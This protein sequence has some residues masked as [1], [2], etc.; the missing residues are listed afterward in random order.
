MQPKE[1]L[2]I[3]VSPEA[4]DQIKT[5]LLKRGTPE[6]Y[7]RIGVRGGGCSGFRYIIQYEDNVYEKDILFERSGVRVLVD[8]KSILYLNGTTLDWEKTL[9]HSG[10]LFLNPKEQSKCG[11]GLSVAINKE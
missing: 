6:S 10:F 4:G 11:C 9:L 1:P 2:D 7:I 8:E 5:Q 3:F